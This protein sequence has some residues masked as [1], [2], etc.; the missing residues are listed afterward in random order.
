MSLRAASQTRLIG[1]KGA[2]S[3]PV[4]VVGMRREKSQ[5]VAIG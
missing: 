5:D 4:L 1:R 2:G 3:R